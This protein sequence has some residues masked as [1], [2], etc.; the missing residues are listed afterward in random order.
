MRDSIQHI[1]LRFHDKRITTEKEFMNRVHS[2]PKNRIQ[3]FQNFQ[4]QD[5][6]NLSLLEHVF[7]RKKK[8]D[9]FV[10]A[11]LF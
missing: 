3:Y 7:S 10:L 6:E 11:V 4:T 2:I 1:G 8:L 5:K 9:L